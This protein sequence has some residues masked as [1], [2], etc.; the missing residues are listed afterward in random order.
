MADQIPG[1]FNYTFDP[2]Q[3]DEAYV[4]AGDYWVTISSIGDGWKR[5][6]DDTTGEPKPNVSREI[7]CDLE[8]TENDKGEKDSL[9]AYLIVGMIKKT[10]RGTIS[11]LA[12]DSLVKSFMLA[13]NISKFNLNAATHEEYVD[14]LCRFLDE[15]VLPAVSGKRFRIR[16][17]NDLDVRTYR[18]QSW[19]REFYPA[20][21]VVAARAQ[22]HEKETGRKLKTNGVPKNQAVQAPKIPEF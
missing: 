10:K 7:T 15:Q 19:I 2:L 22:Q 16:V 1:Q 9:P 5:K 12:A 14:Q 3:V 8:G 20:P 4:K 17:T 13:C 11:G 6:T 21:D 18:K